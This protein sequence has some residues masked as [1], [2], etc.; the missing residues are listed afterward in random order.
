M[1]S[2]IPLLSTYLR[3]STSTHSD[4]ATPT[5]DS[6]I[7]AYK[8]KTFCYLYLLVEFYRNMLL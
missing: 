2:C 5:I 7:L 4:P 6:P 8:Y 3:L 1:L